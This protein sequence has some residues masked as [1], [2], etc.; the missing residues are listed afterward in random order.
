M[1]RILIILILLL[2]VSLS[3]MV[4]DFSLSF[5]T[6]KEEVKTIDYEIATRCSFDSLLSVEVEF[7]RDT[8]KYYRSAEFFVWQYWKFLQLSGKYINIEEENLE[9]ASVD[10]RLKYKTLSVGV[11]ETWDMHPEIM[12]VF[13]K[14]TRK[15]FGIPYLIPIEF[16]M[17]TNFYTNDFSKFNNETELQLS[18]AVSSIVNIYIRY[19]QRYYSSFNFSI[20][21]GI[22]IKI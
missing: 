20:K 14:D 17:I 9:V 12:L 10:L 3:A 16:M 4:F 8:G 22:G 2:S 18:G 19:K 13:G 7:E 21:I 5:R 6:P 11:A 1:K 15:T